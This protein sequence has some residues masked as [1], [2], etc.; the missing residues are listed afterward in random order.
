MR[1]CVPARMLALHNSADYNNP[2]GVCDIG[3]WWEKVKKNKKIMEAEEACPRNG[4][5]G[6]VIRRTRISVFQ[7][8]PSIPGATRKTICLSTKP[9]FILPWMKSW[10]CIFLCSHICVG[11]G[12]RCSITTGLS[13][14]MDRGPNKTF[15]YKPRARLM[16]C[17]LKIFKMT[18]S[19]VNQIE[20]TENL[21]H[22]TIW[23]DK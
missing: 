1:A 19:L 18:Y 4:W 22:I 5:V 3:I 13:K 12:G 6:A 7:D 21:T 11:V 2:L 9:S 8:Q 15:S 10:E 20:P 16:E 23:S 14:S 17:S